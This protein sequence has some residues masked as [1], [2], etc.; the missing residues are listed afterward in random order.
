MARTDSAHPVRPRPARTGSGRI[1]CWRSDAIRTPAGIAGS[2]A[3]AERLFPA[4]GNCEGS[5]LSRALRR[6]RMLG[7]GERPGYDLARHAALARALARHA[8]DKEKAPRE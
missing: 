2:P 5:R 6:E 4:S 7:A 3:E 8:A 1:R